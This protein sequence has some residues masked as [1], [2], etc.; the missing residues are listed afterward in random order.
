MCGWYEVLGEVR[1]RCMCGWYEVLGEHTTLALS[2]EPQKGSYK[3]SINVP[4]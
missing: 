3:I 1:E 2:M 4:L